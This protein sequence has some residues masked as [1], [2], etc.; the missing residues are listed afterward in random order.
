[1][2]KQNISLYVQFY[3]SLLQ[4]MLNKENTLFHIFFQ[5]KAGTAITWKGKKSYEAMEGAGNAKM[6]LKAFF[7]HWYL[8][9]TK[10]A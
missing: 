5:R 2:W 6:A 10:K 7:T 3:Y 8:V 4:W 9:G 1:M